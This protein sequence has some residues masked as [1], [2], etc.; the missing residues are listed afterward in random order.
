MA[1]NFIASNSNYID[2][3]NPSYLNITGNQIT[4]SHWVCCSANDGTD[5]QTLSK[6]NFSTGQFSYHLAKDQDFNI[7]YGAIWT[8]GVDLVAS[9][10]PLNTTDWYH[11]VMTYD[12]SMLRI[13]VNGV[14]EGAVPASGNI[15]SS[16]ANVILGASS[17]FSRPYDG[18]LSHAALWDRGLSPNEVLSLAN[19]V[20]PLQ[21]PDNLLFY[22][23]LNGQSPERD[24][25]GG[26]TG[27][28]NG[29]TVADEPPIP[30]AIKAP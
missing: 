23:P 30:N 26:T 12:G 5:R 9:T 1:R 21:I 22:N 3:G 28:V 2:F 29:T 15:T 13:Y 11:I 17:D 27:T 4:I 18:T 20:N 8:G 10:T 24:I 14:Q 25:V 19:G 7:M 6:W 16:T